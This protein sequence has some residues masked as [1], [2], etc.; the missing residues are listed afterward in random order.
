MCLSYK[1]SKQS[2]QHLADHGT[3]F[4]HHLHRPAL[5]PKIIFSNPTNKLAYLHFVCLGQVNLFATDNSGPVKWRAI[6][7][8]LGLI[9]VVLNW[10]IIHGTIY[11][12]EELGAPQGFYFYRTIIF[13]FSKPFQE[14]LPVDYCLWVI[15]KAAT[16]H[17][18]WITTQ[19][20]EG[21]LFSKFKQCNCH[22]DPLPHCCCHQ[23]SWQ[24][25]LFFDVSG[26]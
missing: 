6:Q 13:T 19:V 18:I 14:S 20:T 21:T 10:S 11:F 2:R 1:K 3:Q 15:S 26:F 17:A 7:I 8:P 16:G 9:K 12:W 25:L 23:W 5:S 24:I 4:A 22:C